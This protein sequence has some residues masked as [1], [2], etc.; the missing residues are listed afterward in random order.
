MFAALGLEGPN[1][2]YFIFRDR[3][4]IQSSPSGMF[5]VRRVNNDYIIIIN[6]KSLIITYT[7]NVLVCMKEPCVAWRRWGKSSTQQ[8]CKR[9]GG[10]RETGKQRERQVNNFIPP[11]PLPSCVLPGAANTYRVLTFAVLQAGV[12]RDRPRYTDGERMG[13]MK[14]FLRTAKSGCRA[15]R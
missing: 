2:R 1:L 11:N 14:A 5:R 8:S 9:G 3:L 15:Q 12:E 13:W 6:A 4:T 7:P 10:T